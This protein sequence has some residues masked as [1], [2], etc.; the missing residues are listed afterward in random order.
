[1]VLLDKRLL[2]I[3]PKKIELFFNLRQRSKVV[4]RLKN[5]GEMPIEIFDCWLTK[6]GIKVLGI[7]LR[8]LLIFIGDKKSSKNSPYI[9]KDKLF[10]LVRRFKLN[11]N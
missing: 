5:R 6:K 10:Y 4:F 3:I 9:K 7:I 2:L 1:M 11:C 8:F